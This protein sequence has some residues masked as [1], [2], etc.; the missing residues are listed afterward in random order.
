MFQNQVT[1]PRCE[2]TLKHYTIA[3]CI[4]CACVWVFE[5][6]PSFEC[7]RDKHWSL[8]TFKSGLE[9]GSS[10][11]HPLRFS[12]TLIT[13]LTFSLSLIRKSSLCI[14]PPLLFRPSFFLSPLSLHCTFCFVWTHSRLW[15]LLS[16]SGLL[17]IFVVLAA[18]P[19]RGLVLA[20]ISCIFALCHLCQLA[21]F[22]VCL[23]SHTVFLMHLHPT[24]V[25]KVPWVFALTCTCLLGRVVHLCLCLLACLCMHDDI[26][27]WVNFREFYCNVMAAGDRS[28]YECCTPTPPEEHWLV[29]LLANPA[30]WYHLSLYWDPEM[31][32][33]Y[34]PI[35]TK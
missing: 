18:L 27:D 17:L 2:S 25:R 16:C 20:V 22:S 23:A 5:L 8:A 15:S 11:T 34:L 4:V 12:Q 35:Y 33:V 9:D 24:A 3:C 19:G 10:P 13:L 14:C 31:H 6:V 32:A 26:H 1:T 21:V 7:R 29:Y 28:W 30:W